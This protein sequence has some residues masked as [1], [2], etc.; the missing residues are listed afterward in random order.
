MSEEEIIRYY[1]DCHQDYQ[2]VWHLNSHYCMH[3]GYWTDTTVRLRQALVEMN[4][5]VA[6]KAGI[7]RNQ[8]VLDAGCGVG[9][10][11]FFLAEKY[12]CQVE[13][14]TLSQKQVN[15]ATQKA[16][17]LNLTD[18]VRFSV[19]DFTST[20]FAGDTF[21]VVWAIESVCH[22]RE[23]SEFLKEA[24]R[25]LKPGGK[26]IV[27]DFFVNDGGEQRGR[28]WIDRWEKAWAIPKFE[29]LPE[30]LTKSKVVGFKQLSEENITRHIYPSAKRLYYCY[31]PGMICHGVL[32]LFGKRTKYNARN[33]WSTLYQYKALKKKLWNYHL[34]RAVKE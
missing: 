29:V 12:Q 27:A 22:A 8:K 15:F 28:R 10:S 5:Q 14:I 13:G 1:D 30:F 24:Y 21:D 2:I 17:E 34:V 26:L 31:V 16:L 32:S 23:K 18:R 7:S 4:Q 6:L 3:Y 20:H 33:V 9:G 19:D 11:A 25:V